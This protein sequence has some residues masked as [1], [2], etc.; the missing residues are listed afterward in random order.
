MNEIHNQIIEVLTNEKK[1]LMIKT[2]AEKCHLNPQ[3]IA[4]RL[5]TLELLGRV[6]KIQIGNAKKYFL[7]D[8]LQ[9]SD[10]I[11]ISSDMILILNTDHIIQYI[12]HSA[13]RMLG[14][15]NKQII[16]EK[17]E[18]LNLDIFSSHAVIEGLKKFNREKVFRIE[19]S[20]TRNE[21]LHWYYISIMALSLKNSTLLIAILAGDITERKLAEEKLKESEA[22]YRLISE[23][24]SDVIWLIDVQ[25]MKFSYVS[26]SVFGLLGYSSDDLMENYVEKFL[27]TQ[28]CKPILNLLYPRIEE[29]LSGNEHVRARLD[30][31]DL[32]HKNGTVIPTEM[33]TTLLTNEAGEV[34]RVLG[35]SRNI[36]KRRQS[37]EALQKSQEHENILS[38][39]LDRSFQP[40][41]VS[42]PD[43]RIDYCNT[44]FEELLGYTC[45]E[46]IE[47]H[48]I[49]PFK[50]AKWTKRVSSIRKRVL[51]NSM[52]VQFET[53]LR[54]KSGMK[55]PVE[56][57][58]H[59]I[60]DSEDNIIRHYAFVTNITERKQSEEKIRN[61][62]T[63]LEDL[64]C[65]RT[66]YLQMEI[67]SRI[68]V[69]KQLRESEDRFRQ[70]AENAGEWIWEIDIEGFFTY[71]NPVVYQIVG[72]TPAELIGTKVSELFSP[73]TR[74]ELV[75]IIK[76]ITDQKKSF[77]N[78][79]N[80]MVH[81][82]GSII[83]IDTNG[84]PVYNGEGIY[85]GYRGTNTDITELARME[86][87]LLESKKYNRFL[88]EDSP[89]PLVL[90]DT[91]MMTYVDVNNSA[92][93]FYGYSLKELIG[94]K[95]GTLFPHL[96]SE[97]EE[98]VYHIHTCLKEGRDSYETRYLKPNGD[99]WQGVV[100]LVRFDHGN[101][102][103][104]LLSFQE[105]LFK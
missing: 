61:Y 40:I 73:E 51:G 62:Q 103:R 97:F 41:I 79:Q 39:I 85:T 44:A 38:D 64:V 101:K 30:E 89:V 25:S 48:R 70:V 53:I 8:A 10:L 12:N 100:S 49:Y 43:H 11:D 60:R 63:H 24:S 94:K 99:I 104:A 13:E 34:A 47:I 87:T 52:A 92:L 102:N 28:P 26:P 21:N 2:I 66:D 68:V 32:V 50:W 77:H 81:K 36:S 98:M 31:I 35:V 45:E 105:T 54:H 57:I 7:I 78:F 6:R 58:A 56:I 22:K 27:T 86:R 84:S 33:A 88:F 5:D 91:D 69:E 76:S 93:K 16:G 1:P 75:S 20:Y 59:T 71:C 3:T 72:Y 46:L 65:E 17:L 90:I 14:L 29:F 95:I 9:V 83:R 42:Y 80:V 37:E 23:N 15:E 4:R 55:I 67:N 82:D 96:T 19:I 74:D 18:H